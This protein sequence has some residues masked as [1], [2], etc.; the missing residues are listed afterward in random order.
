MK[1]QHNIGTQRYVTLASQVHRVVI[2]YFL[3]FIVPVHRDDGSCIAALNAYQKRV[4]EGTDGIADFGPECDGHGHY[5][6][7]QC[8]PGSSL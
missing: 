8:L 4:K 3:L 7:R 1:R 2:L 5:I 6:P